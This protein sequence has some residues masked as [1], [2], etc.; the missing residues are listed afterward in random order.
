[1]LQHPDGSGRSLVRVTG[2]A[3]S[4]HS[5]WKKLQKEP[6]GS[7]EDL[8]DLIALRVVLLT[9]EAKD[10]PAD[11][12]ASS[13]DGASLCYHTLGRVHGIWTPLP[14][15]LKDYISSPKPNGYRSL[16]TTVLVGLQPLEVQ[17]R[18]QASPLAS[19]RSI[20]ADLG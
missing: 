16:H 3:K 1:M 18:T 9:P 2:R 14:R 12:A 13:A 17:I 5:T 19:S 10:A 6:D 7:I 11:A 4:I 15:T 20:S 8:L